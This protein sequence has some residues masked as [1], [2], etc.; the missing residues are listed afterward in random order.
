MKVGACIGGLVVGYAS[1]FL[2]RRRSIV[3]AALAS[4]LLIPAWILPR[5][6]AALS[7]TGFFMQFFV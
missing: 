2:G 7:A 1:Q 3:G 4:M 6:E 5:T